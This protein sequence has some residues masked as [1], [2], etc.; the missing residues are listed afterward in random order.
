NEPREAAR[1]FDAAL[2]REPGLAEAMLGMGRALVRVDGGRIGPEALQMFQR[3][4]ALT[5]DPAPWI[6][7]AWAAMQDNRNDE[8][9]RLWGEALLRMQADDP[10]REMAR[11]MSRGEGLGTMPHATP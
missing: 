5:N 2:R 7:Q 1:A 10:R 9:R 3:A 8:A 11:R 6:Y 4:G